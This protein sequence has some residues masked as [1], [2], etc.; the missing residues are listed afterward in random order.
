MIYDVFIV[1]NNNGHIIILNSTLTSVVLILYKL[2]L[3]VNKVSIM[4][5]TKTDSAHGPLLETHPE[6]KRFKG[7]PSRRW[8]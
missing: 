1:N 5:W 4:L 3:Q 7:C 8:W 2:L 6:V